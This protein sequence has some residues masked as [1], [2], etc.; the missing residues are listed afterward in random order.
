MKTIW[1][2]PITEIGVAVEISIPHGAKFL[3]VQ[4]QGSEAMLWAIVDTEEPSGFIRKVILVGTGHEITHTLGDYLGT[5]QTPYGLVWH[6]F[7]VLE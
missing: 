3:T 2:Y 7:E 1:K 4:L 6:A 5:I